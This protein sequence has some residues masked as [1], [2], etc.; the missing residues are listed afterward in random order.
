[1]CEKTSRK[2]IKRDKS[3]NNEERNNNTNNVVPVVVYHWRPIVPEKT[4][5]ENLKNTLT[6]N[7]K[8]KLVVMCNKKY[9][10]NCLPNDAI[11]AKKLHD[12]EKK[13]VLSEDE[14]KSCKNFVVRKGALNEKK[15]KNLLCL[16]SS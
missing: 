10:E 2:Y 1:M 4:N 9:L 12:N 14:E 13:E 15:K 5:Q 16:L 11:V 6:L 8:N 3:D 7:L